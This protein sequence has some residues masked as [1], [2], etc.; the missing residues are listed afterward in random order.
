VSR[1]DDGPLVQIL[2][3]LIDLPFWV[4]MVIAAF[5]YLSLTFLPPLLPGSSMTAAVFAKVL[6]TFAPWL[7]GAALVAGS[8]GV[9][10]RWFGRVVMPRLVSLF[11]RGDATAPACPSCS[12]TM[13]KRIARKG[14]RA[15]SAFWGCSDF[16][17]CRGTRAA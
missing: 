11:R 5:F 10:R 14:A 1:R 15:G 17:G 13:L 2:V 6:P 12:K 7:A 4:S 16:P 3:E 8:L 9:L